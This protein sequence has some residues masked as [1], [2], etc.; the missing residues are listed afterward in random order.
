MA[1]R[2][3]L[4]GV[5]H[6]D[7]RRA[8]DKFM[9]KIWGRSSE[10]FIITGNSTQMRNLVMTVLTDYDVDVNVSLQNSAILRVQL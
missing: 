9:T 3:D 10:A 7:V 2:L 4:H 1:P 5:R 6:E 8:C